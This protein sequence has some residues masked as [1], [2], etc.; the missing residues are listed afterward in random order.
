M[1]VLPALSM[2]DYARISARLALGEVKA[3]VLG[4][5]GLDDA[6]WRVAAMAWS[7]RLRANPALM[8]EYQALVKQLNAKPDG[9]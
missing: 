1:P 6:R 2:D 9:G 8:Q 3:Q 5:F 7:A 4:A